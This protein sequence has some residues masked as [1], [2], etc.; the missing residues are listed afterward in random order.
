MLTLE[1]K[2]I[3]IQIAPSILSADFAHLGDDVVR[4]AQAGADMIHIDV[5]DGVF[6][7]NI[8]FGLPVVRAIRA[9]TDCTFDVHLMIVEPWKYI[10]DFVKAGADYLTFHLETGTEAQIHDALRMIHEAGAK[11]GLSV[12]PATPAEALFP[13]LDELDMVLVMTVEPGFGN[14]KMMPDCLAKVRVLHEEAARRGKK[15][16]V[17]IDGGMNPSTAALAWASGT[18]MAVAGSAVFGAPDAAAMI[19][20]LRGAEASV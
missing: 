5:M 19:A 18:D 9:V 16:F 8:S 7:P 17:S 1:R 12:K 4:M 15:L 3:M 11:A 13:Y 10:R 6:V 14:Q 2:M 20:Q